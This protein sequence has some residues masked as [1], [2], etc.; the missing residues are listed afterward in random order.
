MTAALDFSRNSRVRL[1]TA[2]LLFVAFNLRAEIPILP[3]VADRFPAA[4]GDI[5][6]MPLIHSS[7]QI[8]HA[9]KVIQVDPWSAADLSLAKT[10]DVIVITD[11]LDHHLD[12]KA[13]ERLRKPG[14]PVIIPASGQS[15]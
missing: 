2:S 15:K 9:G 6:I 4:Q 14:A 1:V 5:E 10:A 3:R 13:I 8:E 11:N 7:V 12:V